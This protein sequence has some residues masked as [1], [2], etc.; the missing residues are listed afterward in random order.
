M[1]S[2]WWR[3]QKFYLERHLQGRGP[4]S[5]SSGGRWRIV[6]GHHPCEDAEPHEQGWKEWAEHN[7]PVWRQYGTTFMRGGRKARSSRWGLAHIVRRDA[8]LYLC[9]HQH[10]M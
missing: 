1:D 6:V 8:D 7:F 5:G 2:D 3:E 4:P 10:L 9:G